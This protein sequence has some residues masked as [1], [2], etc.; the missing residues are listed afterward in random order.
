MLKLLFID[1]S[2]FA[3]NGNILRCLEVGERALLDFKMIYKFNVLNG[4]GNSTS[5]R[6][7][8][9]L[10]NGIENSIIFEIR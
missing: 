4:S 3:R 7:F 8:A 6:N 9:S 5:N 2:T 1:V 10:R